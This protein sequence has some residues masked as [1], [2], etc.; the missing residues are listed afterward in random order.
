M[1]RAG[2]IEAEFDPETLRAEAEIPHNVHVHEDVE[3]EA[4]L[5]TQPKLRRALASSSPAGDGARV[6][7][8]GG[9]TTVPLVSIVNGMTFILVAL[10]DVE[11]QLGAVETSPV[12]VPNARL[13]EGWND[14]VVNPYFYAVLPSS[15]QEVTRLRT[16]MISQVVGEDPATGSAACTLASYLALRS[17]DWGKV[18][19]FEIEQ[20][21]EMGRPSRIL[22]KVELEDGG[23]AVKRV[24]L[25]GSAVVVSRGTIEL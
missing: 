19:G 22:V 24:R 11:G 6:A 8:A 18:H 23:K 3:V 12:K 4:V 1:A 17:G 20:G 5:S 16:R 21:V 25:S 9:A 14:N 7:A 2:P 15:G 13:D 10:S